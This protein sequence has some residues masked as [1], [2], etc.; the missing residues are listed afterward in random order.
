ML[1]LL[2]EKGAKK[3]VETILDPSWTFVPEQWEAQMW[4]RLLNKIPSESFLYC[5]MEIP[6]EFFA[7]LPGRDARTLVPKAKSLGELV[8]KSLA[9]T[10]KKLR[11]ESGKEPRIA[12]LPDG[13]YGIPIKSE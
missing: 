13:P 12:I 7:W 9:W 11:A 5:S 6:Q 8:E 2:S 3:F 4:A 10:V 1:K